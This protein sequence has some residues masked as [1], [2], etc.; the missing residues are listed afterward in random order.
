ME[1]FMS[2]TYLTRAA[3]SPG[4]PYTIFVTFIM[5]NGSEFPLFLFVRGK[6]LTGGTQ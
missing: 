5:Q 1:L 3:A 6:A 2:K 4:L